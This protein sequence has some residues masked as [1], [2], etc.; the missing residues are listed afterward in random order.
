[1]FIWEDSLAE[2]RAYFEYDLYQESANINSCD[3]MMY[4]GVGANE[5]FNIYEY[6]VYTFDSFMD[7]SPFV[8]AGDN[9]NSDM[10]ND[11]NDYGPSWSINIAGNF[12]IISDMVWQSIEG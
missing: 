5:Q 7:N 1:M 6:W 11:D 4:L 12:D 10:Q 3:L 9:Q 2:N 8:S